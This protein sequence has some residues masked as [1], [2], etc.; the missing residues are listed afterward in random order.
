MKG[1]SSY[2]FY[3]PYGACLAFLLLSCNR[4]NSIEWERPADRGEL[5]IVFQHVVK[6]APL[7]FGDEYLNDWGE[8]YNVHS[9]K[10]YIHDIQLISAEGDAVSVSS[11]YFLVDE[12]L[13]ASKQLEL[14]APEGLYN[15]IVYTIGVD[16]A[17]NVSGAQTGALDPTLGMFWTWNTGYVM[18]KLEGHSPASPGVNQEFSYH[19]GG[20][21]WPY[22][23][24][25]QVMLLPP[26][27]QAF[28]VSK[29]KLSTLN[30]RADVNAWFSYHI[31]I[32]IAENPASHA[33]GE[34]AKKLADN[35]EGMFSVSSIKTE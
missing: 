23:T 31:P 9:F 20:F 13:P 18:A 19:V 8:R 15:A 4:E 16:S 17:R 21:K 1:L 7:S 32:R 28:E 2:F 14:S 34:L 10:Y 25:K 24:I 5:K 22:I 27:T 29:K 6:D 33:P 12:G 3:L 30:I 11:D 35:Y 26:D